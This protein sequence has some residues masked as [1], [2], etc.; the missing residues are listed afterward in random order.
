MT[1]IMASIG[2]A[3]LKRYREILQRRRDII[4]TYDRAL[5]ELPVTRLKHFDDINVSSGHLY[6]VRLD[7]KGP[8][9]Y[10]SIYYGDGRGRRGDK[11]SL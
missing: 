2:L 5:A 10:E 6:L 3:Q 4:E 11:C 7:R 9:V 1:D 8:E